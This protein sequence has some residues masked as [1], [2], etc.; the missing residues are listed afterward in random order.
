MFHIK[1]YNII[2][3]ILQIKS[4]FLIETTPLEMGV[5]DIIDIIKIYNTSLEK[6]NQ[7][8]KYFP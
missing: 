6:I 8:P 3:F 4:S 5:A 1:F 7:K 2:D